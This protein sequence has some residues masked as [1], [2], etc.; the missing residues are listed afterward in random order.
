VRV[1]ARGVNRRRN[2]LGHDLGE[3]QAQA[4]DQR[5]HE[6]VPANAMKSPDQDAHALELE[7]VRSGDGGQQD[8]EG[9][10]NMPTTRQGL[11]GSAAAVWRTEFD[12]TLLKPNPA[13]FDTMP[14]TT[15]P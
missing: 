3:Q 1:A 11:P 4:K 10:I 2:A 6:D 14:E 5:A 13:R 9:Q 7:H 8:D 12:S 15:L